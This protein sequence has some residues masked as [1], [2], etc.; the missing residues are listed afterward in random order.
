MDSYKDVDYFIITKPNRLWLARTLL[1]IYKKVFLLN[2]F[3]YFCLNYFVDEEN[4]E[5]DDKNIFTA[6]EIN[7]MIPIYGHSLI[8]ELYSANSWVADYYKNYPQRTYE[9]PGQKRGKW[10]KRSLEWLLSGFI[11]NRLDL[12]AMRFTIT[13]WKRKYRKDTRNLFDNSFRFGR[14]E[15]KY[16]PGDFQTRILDEFNKKVISFEKKN[17]FKI[18]DN[19]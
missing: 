11:G 16:H 3:R 10:L 6:T 9:I 19:E 15:A 5:I 1:V 13:Y 12:M 14:K 7:T 8:K 4:L 2:S 18:G 17:D